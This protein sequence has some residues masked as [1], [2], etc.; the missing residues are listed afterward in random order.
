MNTEEIDM[1]LNDCCQREGRLSPWEN[2]FICSLL[3]QFENKGA[4]S[5]RQVEKLEA[6][7]EKVTA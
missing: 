7:W 3:E 2:D 5:E 6:I 4:L 1:M